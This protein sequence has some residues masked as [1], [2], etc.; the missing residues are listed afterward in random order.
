MHQVQRRV[1]L[2][3]ANTNTNKNNNKNKNNKNNNTIV[4]RL[5]LNLD[6]NKEKWL[7]TTKRL[8]C[9]TNLIHHNNIGS[10]KT[11]LHPLTLP[12]NSLLCINASV[13]VPT[14]VCAL[15]NN[16][17]VNKVSQGIIVR[18]QQ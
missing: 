2:C 14:A 17:I 11:V 12:T 5:D 1:V 15:I 13:T 8:Q 6:Q 7:H 10:T 4:Y 18:Y 9:T 3:G 16:V